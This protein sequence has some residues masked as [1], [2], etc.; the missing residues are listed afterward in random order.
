MKRM[1]KSWPVVLLLCISGALLFGV[2]AMSAQEAPTESDQPS[3]EVNASLEDELWEKM[4][5]IRAELEAAS[6]PTLPE[7]EVSAKVEAILNLLSGEEGVIP[8]LQLS[9]GIASDELPEA[10][11]VI[12]D[13]NDPPEMIALAHLLLAAD[14]LSQTRDRKTV[15]SAGEHVEQASNLLAPPTS[16]NQ[17]VE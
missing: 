14:E 17:L 9:L 1:L 8:Q 7:S 3:A 15:L 16:E 4:E 5:T 12:A 10:E 11:A 2:A 13:G 6:A